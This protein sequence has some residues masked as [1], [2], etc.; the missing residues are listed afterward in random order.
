ML[1]HKYSPILLECVVH[2]LLKF[3][4]G[5]AILKHI[6]MFLSFTLICMRGFTYMFF[7]ADNA[8]V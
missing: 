5:K 4:V 7:I 8:G 3:V 1:A 6:F 2:S